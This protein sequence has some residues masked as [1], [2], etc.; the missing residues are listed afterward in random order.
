M[1]DRT[2][3]LAD[4]ALQSTQPIVVAKHNS[5]T[6]EPNDPQPQLGKGLPFWVFLSFSA[7]IV[8]PI[9]F[10]I[11]GLI[12]FHFYESTKFC[13][14]PVLPNRLFANRTLSAA[15]FMAFDGALLLY[16]IIWDLPV[17]FQGT[18]GASPLQSGVYQLP[19][20]LFLVPA[21]IVAGG[22]V[23]KSG[24]Y[25]ATHLV[26]FGFTT[27]GIGLFTLLRPSSGKHAWAFFEII[28][29]TGLGMILTTILPAIQ[30]SLPADDV[31]KSTAMYAFTCS[32]GGVWGVTIPSTIF[33]GQVDKF[34]KDVS[35]PSIR[36]SL[37]NGNAY[38]LAAKGYIQSLPREMHS[39]VLR[40]YAGALRTVWQVG[41]GLSLARFLAAFAVKQYS[42]S[43]KEQ[44]KFGLKEGNRSENVI[45]YADTE[46]GTNI[47]VEKEEKDTPE[48]IGNGAEGVNKL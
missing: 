19:L 17:Y 9:V 12:A 18:F 26:G 20:N 8:V 30:A 13:K 47:Q 22:F 39:E 14:E 38:Q 35:D 3:F 24:K 1:A 4:A 41:I 16:W 10:G 32:L 25:K 29:A 5:K 11:L 46:V 33:D 2:G 42:M 21:G 27:I 37:S 7:H 15:F 28:T 23:S 43:Q 36:E 44:G 48:E 34:L 6:S 31:V 45:S 40:V